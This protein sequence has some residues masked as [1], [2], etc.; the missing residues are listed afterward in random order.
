LKQ[1]V[2]A[3]G[4]AALPVVTVEDAGRTQLAAGTTTCCAVGPAASV[5]IDRITGELPLL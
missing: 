1:I 3:S 2:S 5:D 4:L